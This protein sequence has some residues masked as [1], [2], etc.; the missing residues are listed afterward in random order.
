MLAF[1]ERHPVLDIVWVLLTGPV[2]V[3]AITDWFLGILPTPASIA[4]S[5]VAIAGCVAMAR[6]WDRSD[7]FRRSK[8]P[9]GYRGRHASRSLDSEAG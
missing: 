7:G 8:T 5:L 1:R 2:V 4:V 9:R 6:R 3:F